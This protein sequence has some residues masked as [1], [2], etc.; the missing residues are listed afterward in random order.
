MVFIMDPVNWK[1]DSLTR[2]R[3]FAEKLFGEKLEAV[4]LFGSYAR[5]DN[6]AESDF[7]VMI[8]VDLD[9]NTLAAYE[10][11]FARF[12]TDLDLEYGVFHSFVLQDKE[13]FEYWKETIPFFKNV[14][15][16]GIVVN[17]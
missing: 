6:D 11:E 14:T 4:I 8:L 13:T 1:N 17:A 7:D 9:A 16:E 15:E 3:R 12:G 10:Y 2:I 5:E